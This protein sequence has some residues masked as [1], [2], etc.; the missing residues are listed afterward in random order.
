MTFTTTTS[1]AGFQCQIGSGSWDA[2]TSPWTL[3]QQTGSSVT[4]SVRSISRTGVNSAGVD[5]K[6]IAITG[7]A[8][9]TTIS[10]VSNGDTLRTQYPNTTF[11]GAGSGSYECS[12][13]TGAFKTCTS[14]VWS[15][16]DR[17]SNGA[18][19]L[20]VRAIDQYGAKDATP[21][22]RSFTVA[23]PVLKV[24]SPDPSTNDAILLDTIWQS[25]RNGK[26]TFSSTLPSGTSAPDSYKCLIQYPNWTS[27]NCAPGQ[28]FTQ[29]GSSTSTVLD[30]GV[31]AYKNGELVAMYYR[32][33]S[34]RVD[35]VDPDISAVSVPANG[36]VSNSGTTIKVTS[37]ERP[38]PAGVDDCWGQTTSA[39][40]ASRSRAAST[41][42]S[43][44][45]RCRPPGTRVA[46][47]RAR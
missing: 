32:Q 25:D 6:T 24:T 9:D 15:N 26:F 46:S 16:D 39:S 47:C 20:R 42:A 23:A 11:G 34:I 21:E 3:P 22:V 12:V 13:D 43:R 36:T 28:E 4:V 44:T 31:Q 38:L 14:G 29:T 41:T 7:S 1:G 5:T 45:S 19:T 33:A 10:G 8:P 2:C 40:R 30:W 18:H 37:S 27:T 35:D 17:L